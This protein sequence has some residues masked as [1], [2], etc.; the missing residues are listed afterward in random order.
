MMLLATAACRGGVIR[1]Y[2]FE[3]AGGYT[4]E[5]PT[6]A[7]CPEF[8][9]GDDVFGRN[10]NDT[11]WDAAWGA[12]TG[13]WFFAW[14]DPEGQDPSTA[15]PFVLRTDPIDL[16]GY[17]GVQVSVYWRADGLFEATD[18]L[19]MHLVQDGTAQAPF[20]AA[21]E[22]DLENCTDWTLEAAAVPDSVGSVQVV[23]EGLC[24]AA[25]EYIAI[26]NL[27]VQAVP[28]P[29]TLSLLGLGGLI[30]GLR[31]RRRQN[32]TRRSFSIFGRCP[33]TE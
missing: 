10:N 1:A 22:P 5:H 2:D 18:V 9:V 33:S 3:T 8:S 7:A 14:R 20:F 12:K 29:S 17:T 23:V 13:A 30:L 31:M 19:R 32:R 21:L 26:D 15:E 27:V 28:E 4:T 24:N 25:D 11:N 6:N 16:S